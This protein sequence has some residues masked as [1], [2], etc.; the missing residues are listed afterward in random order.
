MWQHRGRLDLYTKV[1][2]FTQSY[3]ICRCP[4]YIRCQDALV[5][6]KCR[7][8]SIEFCRHRRS[9]GGG[10]WACVRAARHSIIQGPD[11]YDIYGLFL[12]TG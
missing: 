3:E 12:D 10:G 2:I 5:S 7:G 9:G 11:N 6:Q 4:F 8:E 1:Q